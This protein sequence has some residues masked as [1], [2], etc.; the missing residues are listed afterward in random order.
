MLSSFSA[1]VHTA[2]AS[3]FHNKINSA[4]D[5]CN[6]FKTFHSLLC[7]TQPPPPPPWQPMTLPLSSKTHM[8]D[9]KPTTS[10]SKTP[11]FALRQ[12]Y[13]NNSITPSPSYLS[14]TLTIIY[15]HHQHISPYRH[16]PQCIQA[17]SSNPTA[18]KTYIKHFIR[19]S[20]RPVSLL[21]FI[22][23]TL[24]LVVFNQ[25][26]LFLSKHNLLDT[27]KSGF[28]R[29]HS[30]ETALLSVTETLRIAKADSKSSVFIVLD[31]YAAF[32]TVNHHILLTTLSSL[33]ITGIPLCW[34]E[35]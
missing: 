12:K 13:P 5:T 2:K 33:G 10:I 24:E 18:K 1:E 14:F 25:L 19:D 20:Y 17:G 26:S 8:H 32:D 22:A 7:P 3:Y 23:K 30:T 21:P 6:L 28:R 4:S 11:L 27:N 15:T 31:L 9:F 29:G 35:S 16:L 34:F